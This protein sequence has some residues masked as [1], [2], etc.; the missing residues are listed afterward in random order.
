MSSHVQKNTM[1]NS[2]PAPPN[3]R[4][5]SD[6]LPVLPPRNRLQRQD[7]ASPVTVGTKTKTGSPKPTATVK[8]T[9][10]PTIDML[11]FSL[12]TSNDSSSSPKSYQNKLVFRLTS[13]ASNI[14]NLTNSL[15]T[16]NV[17]SNNHAAVSSVSSTV[18]S[19]PQ[20]TVTQPDLTITSNSQP[21][22]RISNF[23]DLQTTSSTFQNSLVPSPK[24]VTEDQR[25]H[26]AKVNPLTPRSNR[27][28]RT[29]PRRVTSSESSL[30]EESQMSEN[31]NSASN[32]SSGS[33]VIFRPGNTDGELSS[34]EVSL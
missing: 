2:A 8:G 34:K 3:T 10:K 27:G 6:D 28:P 18:S 4:S 19:A 13:M 7:A 32:S 31:S 24:P 23:N 12:G 29:H 11:G 17:T 30:S 16:S 33:S 15:V 1:T 14:S 20:I 5:S 25:V 21:T 22:F 26:V 9:S